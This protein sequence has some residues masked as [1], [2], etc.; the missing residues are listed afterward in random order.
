MPA[1]EAPAR[2]AAAASTGADRPTPDSLRRSRVPV[3][4]STMPTT[5][6]KAALKRACA[7]S[8]ATPASAAARVPTP[9]TTS[10]K[11]SWLTVP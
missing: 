6:N 7:T 2:A 8:I 5:R 9:T 1:I 3:C 11:P 10:R 4:L